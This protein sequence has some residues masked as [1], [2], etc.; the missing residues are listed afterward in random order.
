MFGSIL[1]MNK[2]ERLIFS[3]GVVLSIAIFY[4]IN[5]YLTGQSMIFW[6]L[7]ESGIMWV[8][9]MSLLLLADNHRRLNEE[10][11]QIIR[12]QI[13]ESKA[14]NKMTQEQLEEIRLIKKAI[15]KR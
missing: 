10:L 4:V 15:S 7:V 12:E 2:G 11:K 9:I 13:A 3:M 14:L 8:V 1:R 5:F 6:A